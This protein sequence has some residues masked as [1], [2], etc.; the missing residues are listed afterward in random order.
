M[1]TGSYTM[2]ALRSKYEDFASPAFVIKI[3]GR[4]LDSTVCPIQELEV[5]LCADGSA[6][7]C[8][9]SIDAEYDYEKTRWVGDLAKDIKV[10][11]ELEIQGGYVKQESIF[12]GYV[13]EY[14]VEYGGSEPPRISVAG[15][16]GF[17][18]LMNCQEPVYGGQK[19]PRQIVEEILGKA[20]SAGFAKSVKVGTVEAAET[21]PI[22]EQL[23][24]FTYLKLLAE[25]YC[26]SLLCV[27]GELIFDNVIGRTG[28][29]LTLSAA[30]DLLSFRKRMSLK[31]QVGRVTVWGRDV[32]QKFIKGTA[33]KVSIGGSGKA[34]AQIAP[35]IANAARREYSEYVRTE[36]ECK[37]L[38]QARLDSLALELVS[39]EGSCFGIPELIPGRY[40]KIQGLDGDAQGSF[41]MSKVRHR[42]DRDGYTTSFEIKGARG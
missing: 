30:T 20:K 26:M 6:G 36:Q 10:G 29:M 14:T 28:P 9:F 3:G 8:R 22:K 32:N 31:G 18:F 27:N 15:V 42:F 38:A 11:A 13:D 23:D 7:G 40:I 35:K 5:E 39:G 21:P 12:Y 37:K 4:T 25:R 2:K 34:A 33:D 19:N 16:D 1:D 41:F 17:G 24:D